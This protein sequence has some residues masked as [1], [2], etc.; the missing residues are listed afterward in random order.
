VVIVVLCDQV[1]AVDKERFVD[2]IGDLLNVDLM[3]ISAEIK[4]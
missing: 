4:F 2:K 1:R 3:A